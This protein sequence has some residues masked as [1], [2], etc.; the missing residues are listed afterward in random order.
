[1]LEI[2]RDAERLGE[3]LVRLQ[4]RARAQ[5]QSVEAQ[6]EAVVR[7]LR[8]L[9][10]Y[11]ASHAP[12]EFDEVMNN[13]ATGTTRLSPELMLT[14]LGES[15]V[16]GETE[17]GRLDSGVD[18]GGEVRARFT[19]ER[20]AAFVAENVSRDRGAT[21]R[22][23]EAFNALITSDEQRDTA[24]LLAEERVSLSPLG[25]DPQFNDIW[26]HAVKMLMSYSDADYVPAEYDREL[27]T[28]RAMAV[29]IEHITDDPP[30]RIAAWISTVNDQDLR[31]LDQQMLVD[32]LRLEDRPEAWAS[33]LE[34]ALARLEQ[35]V[36]VSDL[37]LAG[38]IAAALAGVA[39]DPDSAFAAD[40]RQGIVRATTGPLVGHLML[41]MRQ[42]PDEA[43]PPLHRLCQTL[44]AGLVAPLVAAIGSEESRLAVR[45]VKDVLIGFG[46]AALEPAKTLRNSPNPAVRRAAIEVLQAVGGEDALGDLEALLEDADPHVQREALRAII[47]IGSS[48]AYAILESAL[49]G[50]EARAREAIMHTIGSFNDERAAPLLVHVLEHSSHTGA[51]EAAY[52]LAL[53]ALGRSGADPRGIGALK[54]ALYRGEWWAPFRTA[55]LRA[56]AARALHGTASTAGDAVLQ[57]AATAGPRGVRRAATEAMSAPRRSRAAGGSS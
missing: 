44:G 51:S 29:E 25:S 31:A 1:M 8:S 52:V 16:E 39:G 42:I 48:E 15:A 22:L 2:A 33:V 11:A 53:E 3:F 47:R 9:A 28:A 45:R 19:E 49:K 21:G 4:E 12:E 57:E 36:L 32:L 27:N 55:R 34:L 23:A 10:N 30:D 5:G 41:T 50:G 38:E 24:L 43:V 20:L 18:L 37:R 14:L 6:H 35:L 56:A 7:L 54:E 17:S 26:T 13:I 40:A 46:T